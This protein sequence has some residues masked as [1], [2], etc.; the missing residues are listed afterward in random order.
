MHRRRPCRLLES[1]IESPGQGIEPLTGIQR[2]HLRLEIH[3]WSSDGDGRLIDVRIR[4]PILG[5]PRL[6]VVPL[7]IPGSSSGVPGLSP[8]GPVGGITMPAFL[9]R[10]RIDPGT[11]AIN[12]IERS[13]SCCGSCSRDSSVSID[14]SNSSRRSLIARAR[15]SAVPISGPAT[16]CLDEKESAKAGT[17]ASRGP[18]SASERTLV[19]ASSGLGRFHPLSPRVARR[20]WRAG[21]D[22]HRDPPA[23]ASSASGRSPRCDELGRHRPNQWSVTVMP[24]RGSHRIRA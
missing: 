7:P 12:F 13:S 1:V 4:A 15:E 19:Q 20:P 17:P 11:S 5:H 14:E 8:S 22:P 2:S 6:R 18:M 9:G 24:R 3:P 16:P 23:P 10:D 21:Q